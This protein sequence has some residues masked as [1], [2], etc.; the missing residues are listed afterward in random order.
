MTDEERIS[1]YKPKDCEWPTE[2]RDCEC[3]RVAFGLE[4]IMEL[5]CAEVFNAPVDLNAFPQYAIIIEYMVDLSTIKARLENRFYRRVSSIQY[6][7]RYIES[8]A[9]KFNEPNSVIVKQAKLITELLL[10]FIR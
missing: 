4:K 10:R 1:M 6:D 3:E 5:S 7:V 8:N 9:A 2:G